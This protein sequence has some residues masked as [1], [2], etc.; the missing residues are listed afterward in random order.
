MSYVVRLRK[1]DIIQSRG[2]SKG[3]RKRNFKKK[4][5]ILLLFVKVG[6]MKIMKLEL[7]IKRPNE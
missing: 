6:S 1:Q 7:N 2:Q 5:K 4:I 3:T